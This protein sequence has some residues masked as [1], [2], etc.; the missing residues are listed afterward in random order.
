MKH[1]WNDNSQYRAREGA[2][3]SDDQQLEKKKCGGGKRTTDEAF[4]AHERCTL[5]LDLS[6]EISLIMLSA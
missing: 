2:T 3:K 4:S 6:F 5:V 1:E